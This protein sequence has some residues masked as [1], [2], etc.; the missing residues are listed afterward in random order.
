[1]AAGLVD[2]A[3]LIPTRLALDGCEPGGL[4]RVKGTF[5]DGSSDLCP[6]EMLWLCR[7]KMSLGCQ[8]ISG[9]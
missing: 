7:G 2:E 1:M 5:I 9:V 6:L 4:M 8:G 3:I